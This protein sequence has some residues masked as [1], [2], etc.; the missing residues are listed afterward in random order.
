MVGSYEVQFAEDGSTMEGY[1]EVLY[2]WNRVPVNSS[3]IVEYAVIST[4]VP[5]TWSLLGDRVERRWPTA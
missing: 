3:D 1:G 5:I 2:V 4:G